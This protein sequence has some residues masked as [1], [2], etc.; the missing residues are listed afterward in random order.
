MRGYMRDQ[1]EYLGLNSPERR[2]A[3]KPWI[4][5]GKSAEAEDLLT[6]AEECW[7]ENEREFQYC[8]MDVLR[9]GAKELEPKHLPRVR[10]LI[11]T[12]SWWDTIDS[13][14]PWTVG[15]MVTSHPEL[16]AV[17]DEWIDD[18]NHWV[19]RSAILHQLGYKE[20]T[21]GDRLFSY[22]DKRGGD[23]EFFIRKAL[24]WALR[25]YA[26]VDPD[27]VRA[28]VEDNADMLSGLTK[29]EALKHL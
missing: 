15:T 17:M 9:A 1:F 3:N 5:Q 10:A 22:A 21:D 23:T 24:G 13:L 26:R 2:R 27:A 18:D 14:G 25:Q 4:T 16:S 11:E 7:E 6:F 8:A 19:A 20:R 12:K 28:Y 29:R